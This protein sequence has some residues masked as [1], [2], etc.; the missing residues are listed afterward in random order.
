ME[1]VAG[2]WLERDAEESGWVVEAVA[3]DWRWKETCRGATG[4]MSTRN[5][6]KSLA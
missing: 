6:N 1:Q 5:R 4:D 3:G 2:R